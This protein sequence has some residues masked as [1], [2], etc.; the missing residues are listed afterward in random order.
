LHTLVTVNPNDYE[1]NETE[2][3]VTFYLNNSDKKIK[4]GQFYKVQMA[5]IGLDKTRKEYLYT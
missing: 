2:S 5:Y 4:I 3:Y 1:I